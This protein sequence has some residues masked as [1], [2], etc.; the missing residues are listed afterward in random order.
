MASVAG[1]AAAVDRLLTSSSTDN[2][3]QELAVGCASDGLS[4]K[5][6]IVRQMKRHVKYMPDRLT[7]VRDKSLTMRRRMMS[8][9]VVVLTLL[10]LLPALCFSR[11]N[12]VDKDV[13][14]CQRR[15]TGVSRS[16][17][18]QNANGGAMRLLM[19]CNLL[20]EIDDNPTLTRDQKWI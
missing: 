8:L 16:Q 13:L 20:I 12:E 9:Q 6:N 2:L 10:L 3:Q 4:D 18:L 15:P 19:S 14:P 7:A 5:E 11:E 17:R 1:G